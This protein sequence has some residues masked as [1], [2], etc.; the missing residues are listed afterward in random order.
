M[1]IFW[2]NG[3]V[4]VQPEN[5]RERSALLVLAEAPMRGQAENLKVQNGDG[6]ATPN[7]GAPEKF[8]RI[9]G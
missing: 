3:G 8:L 7:G 9:L 2:W 1:R 5:E 6:L 4:Q